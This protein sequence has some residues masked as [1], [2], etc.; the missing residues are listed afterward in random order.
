MKALYQDLGLE[1][2]VRNLIVKSFRI[3]LEFGVE[4]FDIADEL[5][6][7]AFVDHYA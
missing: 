1:N 6:M 5:V 4:V 3:M 7:D 2:G